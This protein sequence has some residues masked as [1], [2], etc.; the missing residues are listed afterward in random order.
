VINVQNGD[1]VKIASMVQ[2][3]M[4]EQIQSFS[5]LQRDSEVHELI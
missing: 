5:E 1:P 4:Q 2:E 3:T